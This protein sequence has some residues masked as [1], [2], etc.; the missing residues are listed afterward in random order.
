MANPQQEPKYTKLFINNEFVDAKSGK[1]F[2]T[3]NPAT[4][5]VIVEVAEGDKA[6]VDLAVEAAKKAFHRNSVWRKMSPLQRTDLMM[7]LCEL[8][9]RDKNMLASLESLD[10]GKPFAEALFD[11]EISIMTLKYYAGWTDKFFGDTIPAGGFIAMTKKEPIGV[12]GQIIPWNYPLLML[13]WKWGPALAVGCT[14]VM[15]PAEQTPLTALHMAALTKEAGFPAGVINIINGYGPTAGAAISEHP[16][17]RKVAFTGSV[18]I[19][20]IIME[21]AAKT[22]LKRV[23]LEL[24]GKSPIFVFDDADVD[25]AVDI[26]HDALFSNHGQ[27]CCA[28]SRTYVHENI[29]DK[30][31]AKAAAKAKARKVGNPFEEAVLQGPQID[32]EMLTKVLGFIESGKQ[33]GAKL[34]YGGKRIGEVGFFV[35]PTV[36]SDVTDDMKIA[37]EEIF[38]PVQSIFKF[39]SVDEVIERANNVKYGL[40]AGIIT[41]D[42][43][44]AMHFANNVDAGSVWINCYDAVLP[45]TP[46]GGYKQSGMG[47]ELGKDG[48]DNYLET[49]TITMKLV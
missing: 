1:T 3:N 48:L 13:S 16:E 36:F 25:L 18:E 43:N 39:S 31:V 33:Q 30:F 29:Y 10:N 8:M 45:Q 14:I 44:K 7:K 9:D 17:I 20:R 46:F 22:N 38:G 6:D 35:E 2:P 42:I 11:V 5:K 23:S 27:S 19:G 26:C 4:G 34:Q 15:K 49:K 28:G 41:N 24:G 40:A 21:A 47:R 12:V 32:E 37:Q